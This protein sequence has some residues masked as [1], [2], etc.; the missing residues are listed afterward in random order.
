MG[1]I[2][3]LAFLRPSVPCCICTFAF[4]PTRPHIRACSAWGLRTADT[5]ATLA[6]V[7]LIGPITDQ[8]SL[9]AKTFTLTLDDGGTCSVQWNEATNFMGLVA[10]TACS[11]TVGS[12][13]VHI[14][15]YLSGSILVAK[16][17][18]LDDEPRA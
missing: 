18:C 14:D 6:P 7:M 17:I 9:N 1:T 12:K 8:V 11:D 13:S 3:K 4:C 16:V 2:G 10:P 5:T 15:G